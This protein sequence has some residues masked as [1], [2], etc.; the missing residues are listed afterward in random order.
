MADSTID[1]IVA[2]IILFVLGIGTGIYVQ[3]YAMMQ[4]NN[5]VLF[6]LKVLKNNIY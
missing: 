1:N 6:L 4:S 2:S 5:G 3:I